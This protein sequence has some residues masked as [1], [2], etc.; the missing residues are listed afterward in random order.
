MVTVPKLLRSMQE[1][2][3]QRAEQV[4]ED[5]LATLGI[6]GEMVQALF[7]ELQTAIVAKELEIVRLRE[8]VLELESCRD[9][10]HRAPQSMASAEADRFAE[11]ASTP[12]ESA[13]C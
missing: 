13:A 2:P 5:T 12:D 11:T 9:R 4:C 3:C 7:A 8:R 10:V 1:V 6:A